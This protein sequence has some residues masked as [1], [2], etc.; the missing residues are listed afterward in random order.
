MPVHQV[1]VAPVPATPLAVIVVV[2][3]GHIGLAVAV[4]EVM[5]T[6]GVTIICGV[7]AVTAPAHPN[8]EFLVTKYVP[9]VPVTAT[10]NAEVRFDVVS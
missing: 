3:A 7:L 1:S 9:T 10:G 4:A 8:V 5:L 6:F 2:A